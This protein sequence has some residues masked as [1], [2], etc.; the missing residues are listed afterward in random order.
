MFARRNVSPVARAL[1]VSFAGLLL[2]S[3]ATDPGPAPTAPGTPTLSAADPS[4]GDAAHRAA[5]PP[6][7][8]V[9][10]DGVTLDVMGTV[11]LGPYDGW[12]LSREIEAAID[13]ADV[14]V[15]ELDLRTLDPERVGS[16]L[17]EM[18]IL[19]PSTT[20]HDVVSPETDALLESNDRL[21]A[22]YGQPRN[23]RVRFKPWYIAI[24]LVQVAANQASYSL[25]HSADRQIVERIGDRTLIG[26]ETFDTQLRLMDQLPAE[27]Q[28]AMLRDT[29][30]RLDES[31]RELERLVDAW[32]R[33]D[34][35]ELGSIARQGVEELPILGAFYEKLIAERNRDW[36]A[37]MRPLLDD[38]TRADERAFMAVGALHMVGDDGLEAMFRV[39]GYEVERLH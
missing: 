11:H 26:L 7:L 10:G 4:A 36:V 35:D 37:Q 33:A 29:L 8:R 12:Q 17:A 24:G 25:Q 15:M 16:A 20:I 18:A 9:R 30:A 5:R 22:R 34:R 13:A 23:A 14:F 38:S 39:A 28:D 32:R 6:F 19:P 31:G 21:L 2:A 1:F 27:V 3:C